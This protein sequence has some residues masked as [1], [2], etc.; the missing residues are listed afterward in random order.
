MPI[1]YAKLEEFVSQPRLNR[2]L[3]G[4]GNDQN[5]ALRLY[6]ANLRIAKSFYPVLNLFETFLRNSINERLINHF[7]DPNWIITQQ[8]GFMS[9]RILGSSYWLRGQVVKAINSTR[10]TVTSGKIIAE[11]TFGFWT[12]L[13]ERKYYR[14]LAGSVIHCFPH[15]PAT[16]NRLYIANSLTDIR[17]FRNR[18]YH[19][20]AICFD[21]INIDFNHPIAIKNQIYKL[22]D[23]MDAD[24]SPYARLVDTIDA[25]IT[26]AR[27]I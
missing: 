17:N 18:V 27:T 6:E 16:V 19:N 7:H 9:D 21:N 8:N 5:R 4:C 23:W 12:C 1:T 2:Y 10:G 11:Q 26:V 3:I 24:L 20:E 22:M 14:V 25:E 15:K 13:F